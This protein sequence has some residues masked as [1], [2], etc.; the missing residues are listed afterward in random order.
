V[1]LHLLEHLFDVVHAKLLVTR[2]LVFTKRLKLACGD[3]V[4]RG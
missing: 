1:I 3:L 2:T 4:A